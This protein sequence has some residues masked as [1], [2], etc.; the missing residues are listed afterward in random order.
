MEEKNNDKSSHIL[1]TSSNLWGICFIVLT[2]LTIL[3]LDGKTFIDEFTAVAIITFM[4][5]SVLSFLSM[6]SKN[7]KSERYEKIATLFFCWDY[8]LYL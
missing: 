2:S 7:A 1:T 6:R 5:S 3:H 8:F 4:I